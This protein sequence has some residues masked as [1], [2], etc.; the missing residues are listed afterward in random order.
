APE[1]RGRAAE[2]PPPSLIGPQGEAHPLEEEESAVLAA[3]AAPRAVPG[4]ERGHR[5]VGPPEPFPQPAAG[6]QG[7]A[8]G[9]AARGRRAAPCLEGEL[10]RRPPAPRAAAPEG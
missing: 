1:G 2:P 4:G 10:G 9:R 3:A 8:I 7:R 6:G 5:G